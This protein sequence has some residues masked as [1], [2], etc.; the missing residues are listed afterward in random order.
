MI[1]DDFD[2]KEDK[3]FRI[4]DNEGVT[5]NDQLMPEIDDETVVKAYKAMLFAR[6]ADEMAVSFQRQGR[7][8]TYPPNMGQEA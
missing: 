4:I 5:V 3:I 6:T 7:M 8:Y 2:P 1:F